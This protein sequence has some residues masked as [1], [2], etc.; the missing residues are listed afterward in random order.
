MLSRHES[1]AVIDRPLE[2]VWAFMTDLFSAPRWGGGR[3]RVRVTSPG[4]L[5]LGSSLQQRFVFLGFETSIDTVITEWDPP[6]AVAHSTPATVKTGPVR[7]ATFRTSLAATGA[8]TK[9]VRMA[10]MR[11]RGLLRVLWP[12]LWPLMVP[13]MDAQTRNL[14]RLLEAPRRPGN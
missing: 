3:L 4:P 8:G 12:I 11:P 2:D 10:D 13:R 14:K 6:H 9:L 5:G 1:S 7:S